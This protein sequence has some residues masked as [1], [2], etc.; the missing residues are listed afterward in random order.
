[1]SETIAATWAAARDWLFDDALPLWF[2]AGRHPEHGGFVDLL[3]DAGQPIRGPRR[4]FVQ[5]RMAYTAVE[6]GRL[7]WN[8]PWREHAEAGLA[9]LRGPC[10]HPD[11]GV[12]HRLTD[13][14]CV[15]RADR[16]LYDQAFTAFA[17]AECA[18]P[19]GRPELLA[20][21]RSLLEWLESAWSRPPSG[22]WEGELLPQPP[23][24]QNPYMHLLEA[25][26]AIAR[27]SG[28]AAQD[29]ARANRWAA[30]ARDTLFD[31]EAGALP[32]YFAM[33][34]SPAPGEDGLITEPGHQFEW[35][36]LLCRLKDAGGDDHT[37]LAQC[38]WRHGLAHGICARRGVAVDSV[39]IDGTMHSAKAR[40]WPQTERLKAAVAMH[41]LGE[42]EGTAE[43]PR[44]YAG[45]ARY[46]AKPPRGSLYDRLLPDGSFV[47][48]PARSSSL[49]HIICAMAELRRLV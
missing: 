41:E 6:A 16:D 23:R 21:A 19:L 2:T 34:W 28:G 30:F 37:D 18:G 46:F 49:Y 39:L 27:A 14:A 38:I 4:S 33:D 1:M 31:L 12:V 8:G 36:W 17:L 26:V 45:L 44:A 40:L 43:I 13:D 48:E 29:I 20:E 22:L 10:R 24:R 11:G 35:A 47:E 25:T 32:E 9:L 42:A 7:G 3:D 5:A 15:D